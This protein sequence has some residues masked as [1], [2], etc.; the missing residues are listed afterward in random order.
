MNRCNAVIEND[1]TYGMEKNRFK[2]QYLNI[3]SVSKFGHYLCDHICREKR[4]KKYKEI[5]KERTAK[6]NTRR[7]KQ[8]ESKNIKKDGEQ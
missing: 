2:H 5:K 8:C 3:F 7:V 6:K 1:R 4:R